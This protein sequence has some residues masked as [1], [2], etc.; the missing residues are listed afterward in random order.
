MTPSRF[1]LFFLLVL[2]TA[3]RASAQWKAY[4]PAFTDMVGAFD[5]RVAEQNDQVAWCVAMKYQVSPTAYTW[6]PS[7]HLFF[8]RTSDGGETWQGGTI[9][10]GV[11][12]YS[13]NIC[14]INRDTAWATGLDIDFLN[15]ALRT[16]DGG[17]TWERKMLTEYV[18]GASY[19]NFLHFWDDLH[20]VAMGDP[21]PSDS[22]PVPFFEIYTT[23]DGGETWERVPSADIPLPV[24]NEYGS[25][26]FYEVR[27]D[28][29]WFGT[30]DAVTYNGKRMFRSKDRGKH[31]EVLEGATNGFNLFSFADTLHG[32]GAKRLNNPDV[33]LIYTEDGGDT[34][35][36]LPIYESPYPA[37]NYVLVPQSNYI[38]TTRRVNNLTGPF[39]TML[40]KDLG[41]NWIELGETENAGKIIF[42][43]PT[44]GYAG[45]IQPV[46]HATRMYKYDG[47]PLLGLLSGRALELDVNITPN[48]VVEQ[49]RMHFEAETTS[50]YRLFLHDANGRLVAR[51][52]LAP[53]SSC[54]AAFDVSAFPAGAYTLTISNEKGHVTR[55][56]VKIH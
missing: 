13:S 46:D 6:V 1:F 48:P 17:Q 44:L 27:G 2:C 33:S 11:E 32:L 8:S 55:P 26:G 14:P 54:Q 53:C 5:L 9:P 23:D 39:Q 3:S 19:I 37:N 50:A 21:V 41:E 4:S 30:I 28:Y 29:V 45:E 35:V 42:R 31:W 34:W 51:Q 25:S 22:D 52:D 15:Y 16:T 56:L 20:G 36:T 47:D 12:P 10:M 40:S 7:E 24:N 18:D 49:F 38:L 43:S